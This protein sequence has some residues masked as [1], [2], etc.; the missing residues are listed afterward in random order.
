ML[1]TVVVVGGGGVIVVVAAVVAVFVFVLDNETLPYNDVLN[2]KIKMPAI[3]I[4][5]LY[6]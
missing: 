3:Q 1:D 5:T 6:Y 4:Q 2:I